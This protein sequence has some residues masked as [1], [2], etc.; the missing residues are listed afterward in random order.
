MLRMCVYMHSHFIKNHPIWILKDGPLIYEV[1][2]SQVRLDEEE[3]HFIVVDQLIARYLLE[4]LTAPR[5][6]CSIMLIL[7]A[8]LFGCH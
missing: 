6:L 4:E 7:R 2:L 5:L 3:L 8:L 1:V